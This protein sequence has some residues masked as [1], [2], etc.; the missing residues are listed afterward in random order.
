MLK[1]TICFLLLPFSWLYAAVMQMRNVSFDRRWLSIHQFELPVISIGNLTVGGTG[2]TPHAEYLINLLSPHHQIALVSRGY[3]RK[4]KGVVIANQNSTAAEIGDE[5]K[6][7]ANRFKNLQVIVAEKRVDGI[8]AALNQPEKPDL[9]VLDDAYQHRYVLPGLS[10]LLI[11][12]NRPVWNDYVLPAGRLREP[13]TGMKRA[14]LI[15]ITKCP[16]ILSDKDACEIKTIV[17]QYTHAEVFFTTVGYGKPEPLFHN[18]KPLEIQS[19]NNSAVVALSGIA[20]P[21]PFH[22]YLS[23]LASEVSVAAFPD[24][25]V[26]T[27][28]NLNRV[29]LQFQQLKNNHK[30]IFTTEKDGARLMSMVEALPEPFKTSCYTLPIGVKFLFNQQE[31]FNQKIEAYVTENQGHE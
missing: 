27:L 22:S 15:I 25:H 28:K 21:E 2:K 19:H 20:N 7:M 6:Q 1:K 29:N 14:H 13:V 12:Y 3:G 10:I 17:H 18:S 24:H 9:I 5:P 23:S 26:F 31:K 16:E 30:Y 11:D 8:T 4:T